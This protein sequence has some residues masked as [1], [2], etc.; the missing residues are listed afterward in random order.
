ME[1]IKLMLLL[2]AKYFIAAFLFFMVLQK[3]IFLLYNVSSLP[4]N[5]SWKDIGDIYIHG[6]RLDMAGIAY[7]M[8]VPCL[9]AFGNLM[10]RFPLKR[11]LY[12]YTAI[13]TFLLVLITLVDA[14][15]YDFWHFKLDSTIF[16]YL[17]DPKN[18]LAS[19]SLGFVLLRLFGLL[20]LMLVTWFLFTW[21]FKHIKDNGV[22]E[23]PSRYVSCGVLISLLVVF[24]VM[25]RGIESRPNTLSKAA[26]SK[27]MFLN[28][29]AINP[30]FSIVYTSTR[31]NDFSKVFNFY[32]EKECAKEFDRMYITESGKIDTI[33][34]TNRPNILFIVM[35][36]FGAQ[37]VKSLGGS[38]DVAPNL[39]H[40]SKEGVF[41]T[42]CYCSSFRTDRAIVAA[43][44]G[45]LGQPTTSI[46]SYPNKVASLP[47]IPRVLR[48]NGYDTQAVYAGD[49]SYFNMAN[50]FYAS[51]HNKVISE[52]SFS[53][54]KR[55][56]S[57]GVPDGIVFNWL[58]D[59]IQKRNR[60]KKPWY[61]TYLTL[62]SHEPF[63]VP[64]YKRLPNKVDNAFAY[65][66]NCL[67]TFVEKL[68]KTSAWKNLLIIC[69]A[70]HSFNRNKQV[71]SS[72]TYHH[73]PLLM[74]GGCIKQSKI[75][76]KYVNQT[77]IVAT[78]LGQL[79]ISHKEFK[80]SRDVLSDNYKYPFAF[81]TYNNGF[82]FRDSTGYTIYDNSMEKSL[83]NHNLQRERKGKIILQTLYKDLS[84][85]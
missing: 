83:E 8:I 71:S 1:R 35:E 7:I 37:F 46:I 20:L 80:F 15:M 68:K 17:N 9:L 48:Q 26:F 33:L 5:W 54:D 84:K 50:Y 57:W 29:A 21:T 42:N 62:S 25:I 38:A 78:I 11:C 79:H 41:F 43:I 12:I 13:I 74:L 36:S 18:I 3:P 4:S 2:L 30:L 49:V 65:T 82:I 51:G 56:Q 58:F 16:L 63:D 66:D 40:L 22:S 59:D 14:I 75:I 34:T 45:Y 76:R 47:S 27:E 55:L 85:R 24:F 77:D 28:H 60:T 69:V 53:I 64:N 52:D 19:V 31:V 6:L 32:P 72:S 10:F 23:Q 81:S 67:G 44:S 70:D 73:V 39:E 61:I